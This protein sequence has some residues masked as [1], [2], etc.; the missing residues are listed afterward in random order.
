MLFKEHTNGQ[1]EEDIIK[2]VNNIQIPFIKA[3]GVITDIITTVY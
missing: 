1:I 3:K 2:D